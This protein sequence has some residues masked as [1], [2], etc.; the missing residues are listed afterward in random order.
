M[1]DSRGYIPD[2]TAAVGNGGTQDL[3]FAHNGP[4]V[5]SRV[6][7]SQ[8]LVGDGSMANPRILPL[9]C[10][11]ILLALCL[12]PLCFGE[13]VVVQVLN[14]RD[15][16]PV[17]DQL[18]A[19]QLHFPNTDTMMGLNARTD[20]NGEAH[21]QLPKTT[22]ERVEVEVEVEFT[23]VGLHCPYHVHGTMQSVMSEGLMVAARMRDPKLSAPIQTSP[24]HIV[25]VARPS[26]RW[27]T[28]LFGE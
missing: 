14:G 12:C 15:G 1:A 13:T 10:L 7:V 27:Q 2:L 6:P 24:G 11:A 22:P 5:Y 16:K 9:H 28:V 20:A 21:F 19:M 26:V 4:A 17:T 8:Q 18:V 25:F 3:T 23:Q